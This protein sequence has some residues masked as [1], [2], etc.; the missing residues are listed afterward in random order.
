MT[1]KKNNRAALITPAGPAGIAVIQVRGRDAAATL[2]K[3]FRVKNRKKQREGTN[4]VLFGTVYDGA[5]INDQ[6]RIDQ[7]IVLRRYE[8]SFEIHCHGGARIVQRVFLLL[9]KHGIEMC[10]WQEMPAER[11]I[12]GEVRRYLPE[13]KTEVAVRAI[14]GQYPGGL[15]E[16]IQQ[17][18]R[19]LANEPGKMDK[20]RAKLQNLAET[21]DIGKRLLWPARVALTGPVNSGKSTL[22]NAITGRTQSIASELAGTTRDWTANTVDMGGAAVELIDTAGRR[23]SN[24][25][26]EQ[27]SL[28]YAAEKIRE[29]E[30]V[31][32][33]VEAGPGMDKD[34]NEQI[35]VLPADCLYLV[36]VNK[37]DLY[38]K[39]EVI[40]GSVAVSAMTGKNLERLRD[41]VMERLGFTGFEPGKP[42]IFTE[43]QRAITRKAIETEDAKEM[44]RVLED[45]NRD[46][47]KGYENSRQGQS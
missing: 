10:R 2:E 9:E 13:A 45:M 36:V 24:D 15:N 17:M 35:A 1:V 12:A 40:P 3:I 29:A 28:V 16:C 34:I 42:V 23:K 46:I 37:Y 6:T 43:R 33:V 38:P 27:A 7:A 26:L 39:A 5:E 20:V 8:E 4:A 31:L 41:A 47:P 14:A 25:E 11:S 32:V 22:V 30:L 44:V 19:T 21:Y 18:I